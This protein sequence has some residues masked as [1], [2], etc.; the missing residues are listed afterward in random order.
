MN[1]TNWMRLLAGVGAGLVLAAVIWGGAQLL[2]PQHRYAGLVHN[3]PVAAA[4]FTLTD[5]TGAPFTL[6]SLRGTW[7]LL[8]YGYTTCPDVCPV[9]L[10]FLSAVKRDLGAAGDQAQIVFVTID[11]ERD[12]VAKMAEYVGH[13]GPD[14]KGLTGSAAEIATAA[15]AYGVKYERSTAQ[16]AV[17]YLMNHSA[18]VYVIDPEFQLRVTWPF[19][20][21]PPE[22]EADLEWLLAGH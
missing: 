16:S 2:R 6:S 4:D 12:D 8:A 20:V 5:E 9:T 15:A 7:V 22:M 14:I 17:G 21:R 3:P 10:S 11:P 19:G 18:Y 13:F 1:K